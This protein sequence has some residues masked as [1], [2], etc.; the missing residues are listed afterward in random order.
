MKKSL[1]PAITKFLPVAAMAAGA[2]AWCANPD[3]EIKFQQPVT[4]SEL[5]VKNGAPVKLAVTGANPF[6]DCK[7]DKKREPIAPEGS[8]I[9]A[10]LSIISPV[11]GILPF[12]AGAALESMSVA[13]AEGLRNPNAPR[14]TVQQVLDLMR[15]AAAHQEHVAKQIRAK[16]EYFRLVGLLVNSLVRTGNEDDFK[17][18]QKPVVDALKDAVE[19]APSASEIPEAAPDVSE[20]CGKSDFD[21]CKS[22]LGRIPSVGESQFVLKGARLPSVASIQIETS[23]A[24]SFLRQHSA[25][26]SPADLAELSGALDLLT[27]NSAVLK[28][29]IATLEKKVASLNTLLS[30]IR[31]LDPSFTQTFTFVLDRNAKVSGTVS[32]VS[33]LSSDST[34]DPVSYSI[35]YQDLPRFSLSAGLL[36]STL[37]RHSYSVEA[38]ADSTV[39]SAGQLKYKIADA[40]SALQAVP[41]SFV[42]YRV[43]AWRPR[44]LR[45]ITLNGAGG[46][47]VNPNGGTNEVELGFGPSIGIG[48]VFL[49]AGVH[50]G[51]PSVLG[52]GFR[53]GDTVFK[54]LPLP[55]TRAW[56]TGF[57]F[58][59]LYRIPLK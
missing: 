30:T 45:D 22:D 31:A 26:I 42:H 36:V 33:R 16:A 41:F 59:I 50:Y 6:N 52:G 18:R 43:Y 54:D 25:Q 4:P 47:G 23:A 12:P 21:A 3:I 39:T 7:V 9:S 53:T 20:N 48:N 32:C 56:T 19:P 35:V 2:A 5:K 55:V 44:S 28:T 29:A 51:R 57:A 24:E 13:R 58:S 34:M 49:E 37:D 17:A 15:T 27:S 10:L 38:Q 46:I 8:L 14:T 1:S 40:S 11:A